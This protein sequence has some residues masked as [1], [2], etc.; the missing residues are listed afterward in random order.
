MLS[1]SACLQLLEIAVPNA[2][3]DLHGLA[4][5]VLTVRA[6]AAG[7]DSDA[8]Q[9]LAQAEQLLQQKLEERLDEALKS[10]DPKNL[11]VTF[12]RMYRLVKRCRQLGFSVPAYTKAV[13]MMKDLSL[14]DDPVLNVFKR[15]LADPSALQHFQRLLDVCR[16]PN[17]FNLPR[18]IVER[19]LQVHHECTR[20]EYLLRR[21]QLVAECETGGLVQQINVKSQDVSWDAFLGSTVMPLEPKYNE[22]YAFHGTSPSTA[23]IITDTDFKIKREDLEADHGYTFGRGVYLSEYVTHAQLFAQHI[24]KPLD[25]GRCAILVC[26]IFCGRIQEAGQWPQTSVEHTRK[27]EFESRLKDGT[28]HSTM[29][30]EWP[31][32]YEL[33]EFV[34]ADDDQVLPEFIVI[35]RAG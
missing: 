6:A 19:V 7:L 29:G 12:L 26:R 14:S 9:K 24:C 13:Q 33:R 28:Y 17:F 25:D 11:W 18:L 5:A 4:D 31:S 15:P 34:L 30:A 3:V 22:F 23:E 21:S 2:D 20:A 10:L 16:C 27:T 35:C 32:N 8:T 1:S